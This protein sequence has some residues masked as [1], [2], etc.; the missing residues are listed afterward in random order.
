[1]GLNNQP[2]Q[3]DI[4]DVL[5]RCSEATDDGRSIFPGMSYE[6]GVEAAIRWMQGDGSNPLD[7]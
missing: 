6:Q 5:N 2:S 7:D 4:D 1:M 3:D